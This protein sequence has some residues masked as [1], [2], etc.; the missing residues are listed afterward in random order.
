MV[1][2]ARLDQEAVLSPSYY[3]L[4][5]VYAD[6]KYCTVHVTHTV[7]GRPFR[8]QFSKAQDNN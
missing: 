2:E 1:L 5:K 3:V 4:Y 8:P 6:D 7:S